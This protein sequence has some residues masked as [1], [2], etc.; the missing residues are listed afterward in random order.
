MTSALSK[1]DY[2]FCDLSPFDTGI[3]A[4]A[5][6]DPRPQNPLA[7]VAAA[8]ARDSQF[9][10]SV[11]GMAPL[12]GTPLHQRLRAVTMAVGRVCAASI[13]QD[14]DAKEAELRA[15]EIALIERV[16]DAHPDRSPGILFIRTRA[17][18]TENWHRWA[19]FVRRN[20]T[21]NQLT[22]WKLE[23]GRLSKVSLF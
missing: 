5:D 15:F 1:A 18:G 22:G 21:T 14:H 2:Y 4:Y 9:V 11:R 19:T 17:A 8:R 6:G 16:I 12:T 20:I 7:L 13:A 23:H 10:L 3:T